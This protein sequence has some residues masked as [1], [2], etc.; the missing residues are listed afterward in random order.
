MI[1]IETEFSGISFQIAAISVNSSF[2]ALS[3]SV[4]ATYVPSSTALDA[5]VP[6]VYPKILKQGPVAYWGFPS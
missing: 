2:V 5:G 4:G 1:V 3:E 6:A